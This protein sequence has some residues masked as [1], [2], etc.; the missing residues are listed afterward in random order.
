MIPDWLNDLVADPSVTDI[1]VNGHDAVWLDRLN[2]TK[3]A[4]EPVAESDDELI[5][6]IQTQV[7][8]GRPT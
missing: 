6:M 4:G 5:E 8:R 1:Y 7:R 3:V 2:R